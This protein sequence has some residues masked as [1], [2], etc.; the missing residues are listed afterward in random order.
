VSKCTDFS[1]LNQNKAVN[2]VKGTPNGNSRAASVDTNASGGGGKA[3]AKGKK[4]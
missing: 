4:K 3:K 1:S 2:G